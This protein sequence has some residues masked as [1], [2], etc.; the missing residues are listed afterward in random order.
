MHFNRCDFGEVTQLL[1]LHSLHLQNGDQLV[2]S[3]NSDRGVCVFVHVC[4]RAH[5]GNPHLMLCIGA[6]TLSEMMYK[7]T[8][9][10]TG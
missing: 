2:L 9:F 1:G 10:T 3:D 7:E 5:T 6:V 4:T 8:N